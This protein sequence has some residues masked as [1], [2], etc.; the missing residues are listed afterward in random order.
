MRPFRGGQ[1]SYDS[2]VEKFKHAADSRDQMNYYVR[3]TFTRNNLDFSE[4]VK[5]L[6][7]LGFEQISVEPVVAEDS[8]DYAI[9][10]E[11]VP[12][13]LEQ[14]DILA[15]D[16]LKRKKKGEPVS[17]GYWNKLPGTRG[18]CRVIQNASKKDPEKKF[19]NIQT[20]YEPNDKKDSGGNKW[21][22]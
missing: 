3:G 7:D 9:K 4:D 11:D 8:Q 14:Y 5:H 22:I 18:R 20:F 15:R 21:A 13:I 1:G 16:L 19:N 6:A 17:G 12:F 2:I 10:E